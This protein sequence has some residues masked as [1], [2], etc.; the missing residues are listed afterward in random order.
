ME[1]NDNDTVVKADKVHLNLNLVR[2]EH[3]K[4]QNESLELFAKKKY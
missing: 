4:N 1:Q 2:V 3:M